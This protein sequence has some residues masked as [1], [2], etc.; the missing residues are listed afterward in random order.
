[1]KF[2][3]VFSFLCLTVPLA[4]ESLYLE[5][6]ATGDKMDL[7][8]ASVT[9]DRSVPETVSQATEIFQVVKND[10]R[11][12]GL[13]RLIE[14]GP[15]AGAPRMMEGWSRL[16]ADVVSVGAVEKA[17]FGR[18][19]FAAELRDA[20][21][22]RTVLAKKFLLDE[23]ARR[24]AHRWADEIVLYFTG[25]AGIASSRVV[26]VNDATGS[27]EV[28]MVD[29]DGSHLRRLTND[30]AIV[31]FPKLSPDGEWIIFT[32][33]RDGRPTIYKMRSDG[34]EKT[35]LCRFDGLNSAAAWMPDGKSIVATLSE[36]RSPN[37]SQVDLD[38]R[39]VQVLTNSSAVDTAPTVSP[40]GLRIA[41]TSD[42]PG[43]PQIYFMD[44]SG[45]NIRRGTSG[46]QAD[47]PHW[48]PLGHL[49]VF[50]QLEKKYF[51]L[52]TLEVATGKLSRLTYGEGDNENASWSPDGRHV[53]FTSTRRGRPELWVMGADGSNP[54]PL[55]PIP[56][57]SFTPHWGK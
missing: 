45:A 13:F 8:M 44:A 34:R 53:V 57:Q 55:G 5:L 23:G 47:S 2:L 28:Y 6:S 10:L 3:R 41:F 54:R 49:V 46:P 18:W 14:G 56:G 27:K 1:M 15:A 36:G 11:F 9:A 32:S 52:W 29:A 33:F 22:G 37:L 19:Q 43:F 48:S 4:A 40:D 35:A 21:S 16:G 7:G 51:D 25:Q 12:T 38:G 30:R 31:L 24:A 20:N 50:T 17:L 26:F 42:R 39:V